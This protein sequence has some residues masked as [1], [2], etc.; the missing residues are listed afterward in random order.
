M[1]DKSLEQAF[2][3]VS[4][5]V[6]DSPAEDSPP[7]TM[8]AQYYGLYK[9]AT[10]GPCTMA[11]PSFFQFEATL[12]YKAWSGHGDMSK[13]RAMYEYIKLAGSAENKVGEKVR[14]EYLAGLAEP[15]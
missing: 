12:K 11:A 9:Q 3:E 10:T 15:A 4:Q 14:S 1:T 13:E 2:E 8:Q 7:K 6:R 5:L